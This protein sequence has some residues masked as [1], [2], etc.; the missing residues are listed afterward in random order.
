M[1]HSIH[2]PVK[3]LDPIGQLDP[4]IQLAVMTY[5]LKM[6]SHPPNL[7]IN[8][9]FK[10]LTYN[11]KPMK[12]WK[13]RGF[14]CAPWLIPPLRPP[15]SLIFR[16]PGTDFWRFLYDFWTPLAAFFHRFASQRIFTKAGSKHETT[17]QT[18]WKMRKIWWDSMVNIFKKCKEKYLWF[19]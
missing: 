5:G 1:A 10:S 6:V 11:F 14:I 2:C 7:S 3:K 18:M 12:K 19:F 17:S 15:S 4:G 8:L 13:S 9:I 16:P